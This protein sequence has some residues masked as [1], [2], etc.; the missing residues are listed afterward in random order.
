[1]YSY[2]PADANSY[3]S[4]NPTPNG[5]ANHIIGLAGAG[6]GD[7]LQE[8]DGDRGYASYHDSHSETF[9]TCNSVAETSET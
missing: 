6:S 9:E 4:P 5:I 3:H 1:M 2:H 7:E 8:F